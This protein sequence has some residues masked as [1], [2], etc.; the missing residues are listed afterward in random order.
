MIHEG[1]V[2]RKINCS[3]LHYSLSKEEKRNSNVSSKENNAQNNWEK[4]RKKCREGMN[5]HVKSDKR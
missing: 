4:T 2:T 5:F 3:G 1:I